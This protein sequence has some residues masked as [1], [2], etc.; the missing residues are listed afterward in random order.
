M[1]SA[2]SSVGRTSAARTASCAAG[3]SRSTAAR[4]RLICSAV[5]IGARLRR[6]GEVAEADRLPSPAAP[7]LTGRRP[8][9]G[10]R[11][12]ARRALGPT[13]EQHR[14]RD[15]HGERQQP[16]D[17]G[18]LGAGLHVGVGE[19]PQ[20]DAVG[21]VEQR[22]VADHGDAAAH[23]L[24]RPRQVAD[25]PGGDPGALDARPGR[26]GDGLAR[27]TGEAAAQRLEIGAGGQRG[28]VVGVDG[29]RDPQVRRHA[30]QVDVL[31][32]HGGRPEPAEHR[33][34]LLGE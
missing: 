30:H 11:L 12:L 1:Q 2:A 25:V 23:R 28:A 9:G 32:A 7:W 31:G 8:G 4:C 5:G 29:E 27:P 16:A 21:V 6:R 14:R 13:A 24:H 17:A 20:R 33:G 34:E 22:R 10:R 26:G 15:R 18:A 19:H 3:V